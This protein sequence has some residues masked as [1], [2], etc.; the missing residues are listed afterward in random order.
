LT[1]LRGQ[2]FY[3]F[4]KDASDIERAGRTLNERLWA[5]NHGRFEISESG[6]LLKRCMFD[7]S[8]W[9]TNRIDFAAGAKCGPGLEQ[10]R[11]EPKVFGSDTFAF[12]DTRVAIPPLS[13]IEAQRCKENQAQRKL[14]LAGKS[15]KAASQWREDRTG[16]L[17]K[18]NP[19]LHLMQTREVIDRAL[20]SGDL[21]SDWSIIV[22]TPDAA[23]KQITVGEAL[24]EPLLYDGAL[25]L[26]PIE[27][28]YD[29][30]RWVGKLYINSG[31]PNLFSF[32][33]G[34]KT[35]RLHTQ[36]AQIELVT[37]KLT[38]ST[39]KALDV[40][41]G[42]PD[43]Y[44]FGLELVRVGRSGQI[45]N[46]DD[47]NLRYVLGLYMQFLKK[48]HKKNPPVELLCDPPADLSTSIIG[49][50]LQR[51]LKKLTAVITAPTLRPD[52][53]ILDRA[54]YDT[55]TGILYDPIGSH[56]RVPHSPTREQA[57][58]ALNELWF[59]FNDFPFCGPLD[60]AVHLAA[61]LTSAVRSSLPAAPG[62]AYDAPVQGSGKT[63]LARCVGAL[64]Q[65]QDPG[66]WP[67]TTPKDDE[68]IRKRIFTV[69][70]SGA[71]VL[72]WDNLVGSFDSAA[73]ASSMTSP[74]FTDRILGKSDS[75][76][77]PNRM[78]LLL[79]GN[80]IQFQGE[81]PR[82]VLISRIDP[83]S[84][85]PF[86]RS[87]KL[88]PFSY[89][90]THRQPMIVAALT[91]LRAYLTH[92]CAAPVQGKLASFEEWDLWVRRTVMF[93]NELMPDMFGDVMEVIKGNQ[94]V[95][96]ERE[97]LG[98]LLAAWEDCFPGEAISVFDVVRSFAVGQLSPKQKNL[99][100][101]IDGL[102]IE[103]RNQINNKAVGKYIGFRKGRII[104]GRFF[105][106]GPKVSDRQT[107]VVKRV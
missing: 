27:P 64:I 56:L 33:H 88:E 24:A 7:G 53:S 72:I 67:H 1:G 103:N 16:Q 104:D 45:H 47:K 31:R 99:K 90:M 85:K 70:R 92:G 96:P 14:E 44:D 8:V 52:G 60:R 107:W 84:E 51:E 79:T 98:I 80:N 22:Q 87:F 20:D 39:N 66:V 50:K 30:R 15:K 12:L 35:Y 58:A 11:G 77:V 2:R 41:R 97:A 28:N 37:G 48:D 55:Q 19:L 10:R 36:P 95:D 86:S 54:G 106:P 73:L 71:R 74:T 18:V 75:S 61:L 4:V 43:I 59:P 68:E 65:G 6:A 100:D 49:L 26:D 40:L 105:E 29:G 17:Q 76:T 23:E 25:T 94:S 82:R 83:R 57:V 9:Q 32:A 93:A 13:A 101:A 91:L 21:S 102:P 46:L 5:M 78:L 3:L 42:V 63:L 62:F 81:L 89:C 34:G 38:D 69:L